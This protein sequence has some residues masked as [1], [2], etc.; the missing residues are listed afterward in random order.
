MENKNNKSLL[1][2]SKSENSEAL[3]VIFEK[4]PQKKNR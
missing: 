3:D 2:V 4:T 1:M